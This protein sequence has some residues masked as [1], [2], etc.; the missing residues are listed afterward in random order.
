M[1]S[2]V[3]IHLAKRLALPTKILARFRRHLPLLPIALDG[4]TVRAILQ[5]PHPVQ[6][7]LHEVRLGQQRGLKQEIFTRTGQALSI[8]Y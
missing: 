5:G 6:P 3:Q 4:Q 2:N 1:T 7:W 8:C